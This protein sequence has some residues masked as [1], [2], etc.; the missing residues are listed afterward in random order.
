MKKRQNTISLRQMPRF[1][2]TILENGI[3]SDSSSFFHHHREIKFKEFDFRNKQD[4]KKLSRPANMHQII[5]AQ[6]TLIISMN[7]H[8]WEYFQIEKKET[9]N[10]RPQKKRL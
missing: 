2:V 6:C 8:T 7:Q 9:G 3:S 1:V 5:R 10:I 4:Q